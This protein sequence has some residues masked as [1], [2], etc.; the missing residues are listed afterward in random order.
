LRLHPTAFRAARRGPAIG[1]N[2]EGGTTIRY[3]DSERSLARFT[4]LAAR[5]GVVDRAGRCVAPPRTATA[6]TG[7]PKRCVRYAAVARFYRRDGAGE[8]SFHFSGHI[9]RMRLGAGG[10]RLAAV[11][12]FDGLAGAGAETPFRVIS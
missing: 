8:N 9:D 11:P 1:A 12:F 10:Y 5:G 7:R 3:S 6:R 2:R 4:V